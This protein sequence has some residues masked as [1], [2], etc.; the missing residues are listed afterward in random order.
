MQTPHCSNCCCRTLISPWPLRSVAVTSIA[1]CFLVPPAM[2]CQSKYD[3]K[4][5][6][7]FGV[8]LGGGCLLVLRDA[9]DGWMIN[10]GH[11]D[12]SPHTSIQ[13]FDNEHTRSEHV[14]PRN[15]RSSSERKK[16]GGTRLAQARIQIGDIATTQTTDSLLVLK[17]SPSSVKL[18]NNGNTIRS[19]PT[20]TLNLTR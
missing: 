15:L 20:L 6:V 19:D 17:V 14:V 3:T 11:Q 13:S 7:V 5:K 10:Y 1:D 16:E 4:G 2:D 9:F 8:R 18:R 12:S